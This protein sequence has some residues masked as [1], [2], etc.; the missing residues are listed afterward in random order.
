MEIT[1]YLPAIAIKTRAM[2]V[3][4]GVIE[5]AI[6][7]S[8]ENEEE[9]VNFIEGNTNAITLKDL[10]ILC[11]VPTWADNSLTISHQDFIEAVRLAAQDVFIGYTIGEPEI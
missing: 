1:N 3:E 7:V 2:M 8:D 5:D 6:I 10:K 4:Q 11:V 9:V